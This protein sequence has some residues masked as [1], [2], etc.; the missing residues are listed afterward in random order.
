MTQMS[1]I[2]KCDICGN[3]VEMVHT[4]VGELVCCGQGMTL[5]EEKSEE[6]G[7][8]KHRPVIDGGE[9]KVGSVPHP[10]EDGHHI[11]WVEV[12]NGDDVCRKTLQVGAEPKA[13][14]CQ[15]DIKKARA[16]CNIHGLWVN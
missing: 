13:S 3:I 2:Y 9:V 15:K 6:E 1:Q 16:Y 7:T 11:E 5:Q 14:F 8:E 12:L 4:G 10:M